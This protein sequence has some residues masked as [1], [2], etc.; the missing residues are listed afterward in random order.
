M[1][2]ANILSKVAIAR[3]PRVMQVEGMFDLSPK[4]I[5][6]HRIEANLELPD[7]WSVGAIVGPSGSGKSTVARKLFGDSLLT[8]LEWPENQSVIDGF[9][10]SIG[11]KD[12]TGLLSSVGFS[13]PPAWLRPFRVLSN[14]EQFRVTMARAMAESTSLI[15]VDEFTS[16]VDRTVAKIGSAAISRAIRRRK[17]QLIAV[18]CHYDILEWLEPDWVF[19]PHTGSFEVTSGHLRRPQ[20][21]VKICRVHSSAWRLFRHHH[22]LSAE[23]SSSAQCF[24][25]FIDEQPAAFTS[26]VHFPHPSDRTY[27]R[28][29]RTV[30]L[31]DFQG[32]GLGNRISEWLGK[33]L[34]REGWRF[35]STT[36][37]PAM[38]LHRYKSSLWRVSRKMSR[39][40]R[41]GESSSIAALRNNLSCSRLTAGFEFI[42]RK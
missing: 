36:S 38:I 21:N 42:S 19:Q 24:V 29:H 6:E 37:H 13:S 32:V 3:T 10:K 9:D 39:V 7:N 18:S 23:I 31:P 27:K 12:I 25:A 1:P 15:V 22:Y 2:S 14:G 4:D 8:G 17:Q 35:I 34:T 11:I 26:Y 41:A 30:V 20:I 5:S 16:V 40:S 28:E 33:K